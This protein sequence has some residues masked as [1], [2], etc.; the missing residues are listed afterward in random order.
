MIVRLSTGIAKQ[1]CNGLFRAAAGITFDAGVLEFRSGAPPASPDLTESGDLVCS[2]TLPTPAFTDATA[3]ADAAYGAM[4]G[5][6]QDL[7][8]DAAGTIAHARFR[9]SGD[10]GGASGTAARI[11]VDVGATGS[12]CA[13]EVDNPV[14]AEAQQFQVTSFNFNVPIGDS[15]EA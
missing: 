1:L 6:W 4:A 15:A 2:V 13:I 14:L 3:D 9:R 12:G 7:S 11:D 5:T 10:A 8:A